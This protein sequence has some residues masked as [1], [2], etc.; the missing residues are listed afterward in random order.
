M[1]L[2]VWD[3]S[4]SWSNVTFQHNGIISSP[5]SKPHRSQ[6]SIRYVFILFVRCNILC[7]LL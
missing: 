1:I 2:F 4:C 5:F 3:K 7:F 6:S